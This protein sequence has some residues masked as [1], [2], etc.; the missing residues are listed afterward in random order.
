[1]TATLPL[2]E[3]Q[4][5]A[6][7]ELAN[8]GAG[9]AATSLSQLLSG[10][11]LAFQAPEAWGWTTEGWAARLAQEVPWVAGV[12]DVQGDVRG[13]L[14]LL[15]SQTDSETFAAQ[16]RSAAPS[17][18]A[19]VDTLVRRAAQ[20]MG[21]SALL[22]MGRLTGLAFAPTEPVLRRSG[23]KV[24]AGGEAAEA[25]HLVLEVRLRAPAFAAQFLFL[26][27]GASLGA[28]LRSLRV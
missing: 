5:D 8:V 27:E 13:V 12:L 9:H 1:V 21:A 2:T 28:L 20:A 6:L 17:Q 3:L 22:A 15:F 24:P 26:P 16:L 23:P 4:C 10:E 11:R 14:W 18:E 25:P 19:S 7:R